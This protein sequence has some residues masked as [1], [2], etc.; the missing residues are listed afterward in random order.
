M[1]DVRF[2]TSD[3]TIEKMNYRPHQSSFLEVNY[4]NWLAREIQ[5]MPP[6]GE[7]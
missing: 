6:T 4:E 3:I 5:Y 7:T 2:K 1:C